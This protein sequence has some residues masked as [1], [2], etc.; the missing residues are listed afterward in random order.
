MDKYKTKWV[1]GQALAH[2]AHLYTPYM[3]FDNHENWDATINSVMGDHFGVEVPVAPSYCADLASDAG[4]KEVKLL[5]Q[6]ARLGD[7]GYEGRSALDGKLTPAEEKENKRLLTLWGQN[8]AAGLTVGSSLWAT[9]KSSSAASEGVRDMAY[10]EGLNDRAGTTGANRVGAKSSSAAIEGVRDMAYWEGLNDAAG[11]TGANRVGAKSS[12]AAIEGV[13]D[14]AYFEGI[15][16]AAG[17]TGAN[18]VSAGSGS[19]AIA[20]VRE[21]ASDKGRDGWASQFDDMSHDEYV[22]SQTRPRPM[23]RQDSTS[24]QFRNRHDEPDP[25]LCCEHTGKSARE[26]LQKRNEANVTRVAANKKPYLTTKN[27][28]YKWRRGN[29]AALAQGETFAEAWWFCAD[30]ISARKPKK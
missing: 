15:N 19:A 21:A 3:T 1:P 17:T 26:W 13:L 11:T 14:M 2:P 22:E 28:W 5:Q 8:H 27:A 23:P 9:A 16:N 12:S 25:S 10:W 4:C 7:V 30:K 24:A 20:A 29:K 18:R 6:K